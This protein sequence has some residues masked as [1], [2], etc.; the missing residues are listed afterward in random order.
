MHTHTREV[1]EVQGFSLLLST[2]ELW[3]SAG[4]KNSRS[5]FFTS[6]WSIVE[7]RAVDKQLLVLNIHI[8][9]QRNSLLK[10]ERLEQEF[11]FL[12]LLVAVFFC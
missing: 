4:N 12:S 8:E 11:Y 5:F 9:P 3:Q 2:G 6:V 7:M 10:K 1:L